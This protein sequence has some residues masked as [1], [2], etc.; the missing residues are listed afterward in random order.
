M[1]GRA[2]EGVLPEKLVGGVRPASQNP[3]PIYDQNLLFSLPYLDPDQKFDT[4][5]KTCLIIGS[6]VQSDV[7]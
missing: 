6:P 3:Y 5:F 7:N 4:Q 1:A 2:P